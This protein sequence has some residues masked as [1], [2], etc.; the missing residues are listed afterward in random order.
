MNG[1]YNGR[2]VNSHRAALPN[3]MNAKVTAI[4][5]A[6]VRDT[7]YELDVSKGRFSTYNLLELYPTS[8]SIFKL[9]HKEMLESVPC[10]AY[11]K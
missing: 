9:M 5:G 6:A 1:L 8:M 4:N 11:E 3:T 10:L 2:G 7:V